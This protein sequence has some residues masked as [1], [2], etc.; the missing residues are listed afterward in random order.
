MGPPMS[1]LRGSIADD[2]KIWGRSQLMALSISVSIDL[3]VKSGRTNIFMVEH[4][5]AAGKCINHLEQQ[6]KDAY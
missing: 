3:S 2:L 6:E 1:G 5:Y 4:V